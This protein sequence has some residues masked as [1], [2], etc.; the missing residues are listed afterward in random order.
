MHEPSFIFTTCQAGAERALKA[1][2]ARLW[3]DLRPA[4]SRPGFV[5]FKLPP[6]HGLR[7]DFDP[8]VVFA[9]SHGFSLGKVTGEGDMSRAA[10]TRELVESLDFDEL[11]VVARGDEA[12]EQVPTAAIALCEAHGLQSV[13][14]ND[15]AV[16]ARLTR[17]SNPELREPR[18]L[19]CVLIEPNEWWLGYHRV[20]E[21]ATSWPG[22]WYLT[23]PPPHAVSRA[24][25]KMDEAL[26][27][28]Q[29]PVKTGEHAVEI[30]CSPGGASQAL[31][32]RGLVV[33]GVDPAEVDERV[34]AHPN[35]TYIRKRGHEVKRREFRKMRWL[36][37]DMNVAPQYTL[38]TV[39][40]IVTHADVD[41]RGMLL[42]L[43]LLDWSL[44]EEIPAYLD[45]VRNWG[46]VDVRARQLSHNR[47]E[48]C[49]VARRK[50]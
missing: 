9:R 37:A 21:I 45:R 31:L 46:Y 26:T 40:A 33:L 18:V 49:V 2:M 14:L 17:M 28:S 15:V 39:E 29:L 41:V 43:K 8:H 16:A 47:Q 1:E 42:T 48:I 32:D 27:W 4:F 7:N 50:G 12:S 35:F 5:T 25:V 36:T 10:A 13:G 20:T 11:H 22:G 3:P 24:Y 23:P 34:L 6:E 30:G 38:D 44:A 19:D